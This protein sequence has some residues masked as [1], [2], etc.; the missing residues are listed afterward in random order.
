MDEKVASSE[1]ELSRQLQADLIESRNQKQLSIQD[2]AEQLKISEESLTLFESPDFDLA[3]LDS[4]M[5]GYLR[6]YATILSVDLAPY[7]QLLLAQINKNSTLKMI[8]PDEY[9]NKKSSFKYILLILLTL[10]IVI[11]L[12]IG[13]MPNS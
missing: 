1:E 3:Q 6:S 7:E 10:L 8:T 9:I 11:G 12:V 5:R 4:F 2:I 13:Y